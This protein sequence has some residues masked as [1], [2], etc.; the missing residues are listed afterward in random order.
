MPEKTGL[1]SH[2]PHMENLENLKMIHIFPNFRKP[3]S[4]FEKIKKMEIREHYICAWKDL[5][6]PFDQL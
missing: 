3:N 6:V 1:F 5:K 2:E 4:S